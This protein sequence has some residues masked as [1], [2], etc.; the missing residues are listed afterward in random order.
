[1][2][3]AT[4][5]APFGSETPADV[6]ASDS[7]HLFARTKLRGGTDD[8]PTTARTCA[9]AGLLLTRCTDLRVA[10]RDRGDAEGASPAA[11]K[12]LLMKNVIAAC[13][14]AAALYR[15]G[16]EARDH[17]LQALGAAVASF[18]LECSGA[19]ATG[20][21]YPMALGPGVFLH[22]LYGT[23]LL[24]GSG[25]K[26]MLRAYLLLLPA[27]QFRAPFASE[28]AA[29]ALDDKQCKTLVLELAFGH[30]GEAGF[31]DV[32]DAWVGPDNVEACAAPKEKVSAALQIDVIT[33]HHTEYLAGDKPFP[34]DWDQ[35][36]PV[37][38]LA[39]AGIFHFALV[40]R[41]GDS[42]FDQALFGC[43]REWLL[44]ALCGNGSSIAQGVG[45]KT[46]S[47]YGYFKREEN[48]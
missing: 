44:D 47:G 19:L 16:F 1:M 24:A 3:T 33:P 27:A 31:V 9:H 40:W 34:A 45:A 23:P 46:A 41:G 17:M 7:G 22:H 39:V 36:V 32:L 8:A 20:L 10:E 2:S 13:G 14:R 35:P 15:T 21:G 6:D 12:A 11:P 25:I 18:A 29:A 37:P 28:T 42:E 26:G 48:P 5:A 38:F 30:E 4:G 43:L